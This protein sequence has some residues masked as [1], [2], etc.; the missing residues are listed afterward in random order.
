M[1]A[2]KFMYN[3]VGWVNNWDSKSKEVTLLYL[4]FVES[5]YKNKNLWSKEKGKEGEQSFHQHISNKQ[6]F[7]LDHHITIFV[8]CWLMLWYCEN[9]HVNLHLNLLND[10]LITS[11]MANDHKQ[12]FNIVTT[13]NSCPNIIYLCYVL[14]P[15]LMT[16]DWWGKMNWFCKN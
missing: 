3:S 13:N 5:F 8:C 4:G 15:L 1:V 10:V 16:I 11:P 12:K 14:C 2:K 9:V 6:L 7:C